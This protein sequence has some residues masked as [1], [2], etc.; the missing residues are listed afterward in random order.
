VEFF[1]GTVNFSLIAT[2]IH[3]ADFTYFLKYSL[4]EN[5]FAKCTFFIVLYCVFYGSCNCV[6]LIFTAICTCFM[7]FS[8]FE[9]IK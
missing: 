2:F 4:L 9:Q 7:L 3:S 8:F 6:L 1:P 5:C